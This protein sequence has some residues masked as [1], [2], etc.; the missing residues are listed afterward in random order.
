MIA[1]TATVGAAASLVAAGLFLIYG[2]AGGGAAREGDKP[3]A[4]E[5]GRQGRTL[6]KVRSPKVTGGADSMDVVGSWVTD[7]SYA[8]GTGE[9]VVGMDPG[10]GERKWELPLDGRICHSSERASASGKAAVVVAE[11]RSSGSACDQ[12]VVFDVDSGKKEWQQELPNGGGS[13]AYET[14]VAVSREVVAATWEYGS[15]AYSL[16]GGSPLWKHDLD[17]EG[18]CT[19]EDLSGGEVLTVV[20]K[21]GYS[22]DLRVRKLNPGTGTSSWESKLPGDAETGQVV[23][24][25][26]VVVAVDTDPGTGVRTDVMSVGEDGKLTTISLGK[27]KYVLDPCQLYAES[28]PASVVDDDF[29]YVPSLAQGDGD[30]AQNEITAFDLRTG[31]LAWKSG[32]GKHRVIVPLRMEDGELIA[33]RLP[34]PGSGGEVVA[35]DPAAHGKKQEV[36]LRNPKAGAALESAFVRPREA[37]ILY[38]D[39]RLFLQQGA[40]PKSPDPHQKYVSAVFGA[41]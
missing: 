20:V 32:A 9:T 28:C 33:Y 40:V 23:S 29:L 1:V 11:S 25:D 3:R 26:P 34:A 6:F 39:G 31:K 36:L 17:D 15:A 35:I 19:N 38:E 10:S 12:L 22:D 24:S 2:D 5:S 30:G 16:S 41:G 7:G 14:E 8:R 18:D 13:S 37:R 21:C 27:E 4:E